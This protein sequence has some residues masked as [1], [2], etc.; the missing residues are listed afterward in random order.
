MRVSVRCYS[1][2]IT[3]SGKGETGR[4]V[5]RQMERPTT[6]A[7]RQLLVRMMMLAA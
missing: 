2:R 3:R 5:D 4:L 7:F 6:V 1:T